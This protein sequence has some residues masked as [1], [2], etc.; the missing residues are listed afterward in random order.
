MNAMNNPMNEISDVQSR[1]ALQRP[2]KILFT[3]SLYPYPTLPND[4]SLTDATGARFTR[5]D[6]IFCLISHS[7]HFA[8]H[9]LAQNI[10]I[11]SVILEYPRW[12]DFTT[13]VKKGYDIIGISALPCTW[14][15]Y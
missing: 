4:T 5:A 2:K 3:S 8:N 14:K 9:V 15:V 1:S 12:N 6:G 10:S 7:H 11:P 13:E